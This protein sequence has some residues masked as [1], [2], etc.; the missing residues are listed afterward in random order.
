MEL[1]CY[2]LHCLYVKPQV[3][4]LST[5]QVSPLSDWEGVG[6]WLGGP[7]LPAAGTYNTSPVLQDIQ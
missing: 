2:Q 5:F 1:L 7:D 4:S 3:L 6:E